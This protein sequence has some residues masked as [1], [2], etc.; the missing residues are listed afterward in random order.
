MPTSTR[1][2]GTPDGQQV[3]LDQVLEEPIKGSSL[4]RD[5]ARRLFHTPSAMVGLF[6]IG[7][8]VFVAI[9]APLIAPYD[10]TVGNIVHSSSRPRPS[11]CWGPTSRAGTS[12]RGS[13][14]VPGRRCGC[15]SCRSPSA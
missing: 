1:G 12:C 10:P 15:R 9:F 8:F 2:S 14:G 7:L 11:T 6:L 13:C 4:W 3:A 5:A